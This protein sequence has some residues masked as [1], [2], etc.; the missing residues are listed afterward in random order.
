MTGVFDTSEKP[1]KNIWYRNLCL[2][3]QILDFPC[4]SRWGLHT[5]QQGFCTAPPYKASPDPSGFEAVAG[6]Y[7]LMFPPPCFIVGMVF[8]G[9]YSSFF[10]LLEFRPKSVIYV[11][12][13]HKTFSHS[14][15]GSSRWSVATFSEPG[16]AGLSRRTLNML[17]YFNP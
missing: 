8:L 13:D 10:L 1:E 6:Q 9:M 12:S 5:L 16:H 14:S 15:F 7:G 4:S 17:Q 11:S 3:L 2:Q